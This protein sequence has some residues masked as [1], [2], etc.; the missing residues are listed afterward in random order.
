MQM[1]LGLRTM[2]Q[3]PLIYSESDCLV[4]FRMTLLIKNTQISFQETCASVVV[5]DSNLKLKYSSLEGFHQVFCIQTLSITCGSLYEN[6]PPRLIGSGVIESVA[7]LKC[8][9]DFLLLLSDQ[10]VDLSAPSPAPCLP[11]CCHAS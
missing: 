7:L 4:Y 1:L 3:D 10:D 6:G 2:L 8:V 11:A 5:L 9:S